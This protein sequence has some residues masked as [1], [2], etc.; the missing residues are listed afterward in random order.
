MGNIR[1]ILCTSILSILKI[2]HCF[3]SCSELNRTKGR[4]HEWQLPN[5]SLFTINLSF[6]EKLSTTEKDEAYNKLLIA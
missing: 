3:K 4:T 6:K 1:F 5:K 2:L